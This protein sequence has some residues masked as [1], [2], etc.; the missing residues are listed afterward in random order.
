[1]AVGPK[2]G[3]AIGVVIGAGCTGYTLYTAHNDGWFSLYMCLLG[4]A[5]FVLGLAF[6]ALPLDKLVIP[7]EVDGRR[8]YD[9]RNPKYTTL[10]VCLLV[11]GFAASGLFFL[12]LKYGMRL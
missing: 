7:T 9:L 3:G 2:V 1:M 4:P 5:V 10:G 6:L 8:E 12:Y 11:L